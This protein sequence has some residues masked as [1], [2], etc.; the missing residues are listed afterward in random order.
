VTVDG[1]IAFE[2]RHWRIV[3]HAPGY[4]APDHDTIHVYSDHGETVQLF[5]AG[6]HT[7]VRE[8]PRSEL[9]KNATEWKVYTG[10]SSKDAVKGLGKLAE[11]VAAE[12]DALGIQPE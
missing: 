4:R 2:Q 3:A 6:Y 5:D 1:I 8:L 7:I 12:L 11:R 9:P 10:Y